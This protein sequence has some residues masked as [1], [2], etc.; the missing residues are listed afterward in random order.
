MALPGAKRS[1]APGKAMLRAIW[2]KSGSARRRLKV[3]LS[4]MSS[5]LRRLAGRPVGWAGFAPRDDLEPA[6]ILDDIPVMPADGSF[7]YGS[8][9][10]GG[11]VWPD[12][13]ASLAGRFSR[14]GVALDPVPPARPAVI[15]MRGSC[16][17]GGQLPL[18]FGHLVAECAGRIMVLARQRPHDTM[19]VLAPEGSR[20][21]NLHGHVKEVLDWCG[22]AQDRLCLVDRPMLCDRL[23]TV[24]LPEEISDSTPAP[25]YL[26]LLEENAARLALR[27][28]EARRVYV[29]R[30]GM[31]AKA[32]GVQ[33][34]ERYLIDLLQRQGFTILHPEAVPLRRQMELYAG[35]ET[36]VFAEGSA[37][38]G[39]QLIGWRDQ[40]IAVINRRGGSRMARS[41]LQARSRATL[42]VD[43]V[44]VIAVPT[45][46]DG[47]AMV[48]TGLCFL[49]PLR[50]HAGLATAGV[51]LTQDWDPL[52]FDAAVRQ[53][54][55][56]WRRVLAHR[57]EFD[58][59]A[60]ILELMRCSAALGY[61]G[62]EAEQHQGKT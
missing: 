2:S 9:A 57:P 47:R 41:A 5:R 29:A 55:A 10:V 56:D 34:G 13:Y 22:L 43:A 48:E 1:S 61:G 19:L 25:G 28:A 40:M 54:V 35:A 58:G 46:P 16:L 15:R 32:C 26:A 8:L 31:L 6:T 45:A 39:R 23:R 14:G 50:L 33:A 20:Q 62:G 7:L 12:G 51:D 18:H 42:H 21:W 36:L 11:P 44:Q 27:P 60:S 38:H 37:L 52:A 53:D 4:R 24:P 59:P 3:A 30:S 49:D 17:W